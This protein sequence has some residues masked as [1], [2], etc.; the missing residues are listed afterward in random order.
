MPAVCANW[1]CDDAKA[2]TTLS[3][4]KLLQFEVKL[5]ALVVDIISGRG[6]RLMTHGIIP[7]LVLPSCHMWFT[8]FC[9]P[10]SSREQE[11]HHLLAV[12][13]VSWSAQQHNVFSLVVV[14]SEMCDPG[15]QLDMLSVMKFLG[16][17]KCSRRAIS[18]AV[19][20]EV[21]QHES[22]RNVCFD[23]GWSFPQNLFVAWV[24]SSLVRRQHAASPL[25]PLNLAWAIAAFPF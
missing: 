3:H 24:D 10:H 12:A 8:R 1:C 21:N 11:R 16:N 4:Q 18:V 17:H 6:M 25:L 13:F 14:L 5:P 15:G 20:T 2:S 7:M 9:V 22:P 19:W 23:T